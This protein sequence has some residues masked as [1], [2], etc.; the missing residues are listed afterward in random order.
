[1]VSHVLPSN[2]LNTSCGMSTSSGAGE[3]AY[4]YSILTRL[5]RGWFFAFDPNTNSGAMP[6]YSHI[7]SRTASTNGSIKAWGL[8]LDWALPL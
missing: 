1:M 5:I 2:I 6:K 8:G 3:A 7:I 4:L